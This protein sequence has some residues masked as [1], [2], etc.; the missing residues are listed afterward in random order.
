M[1]RLLAPAGDESETLD[2][3]ERQGQA[4][5]MT[6]LHRF[7]SF[8]GVSIGYRTLGD[9]AGWP[10][11]LLHGF[12]AGAESNWFLPGIAAAVAA[13][14][15][16]VIAP[17][18]RGH[19][20]SDAPSD[21]AA[22]PPDVLA[23][24]QEALVA[25]L[26]LSDYDLVGYSLGART[27]VRMLTRGA[28]PSKLVLAGMG[29]RGLMEAGARAA[30]FEDAIRHGEAA[31]DPRAGRR[32]QAMMAAGGLKPEAMLGVLASFAA[33]SAEAIAAIDVPTLVVAG[34]RDDDNG[35][36]EALAA[37]MADA[38]AVRVPGDHLSAVMEPALA[39]TIVGF[40]KATQ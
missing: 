3:V 37:M 21:P 38:R 19:G 10:T 26:H 8:D 18:L 13:T 30:M 15:R 4:E 11:L 2:G 27:A 1:A 7:Q 5:A 34:Q 36:V 31:R 9:P 33:T 28:R 39:E 35:S 32:V 25:H 6:D 12:L 40:L 16:R 14:R 29:E 22:W 17:D 20:R 23:R 24:D